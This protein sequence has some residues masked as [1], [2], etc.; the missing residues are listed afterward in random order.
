MLT[1]FAKPLFK[2]PP[3]SKEQSLVLQNIKDGRN[4][5]VDAVA[6]SGKTTTILHICKDNP[7]KKVLVITYNAR[8]KLETRQKKEKLKLFNVEIHSYHGFGCKYYA[9]LCHTDEHILEILK[10]NKKPKITINYDIIILDEQQDMIKIYYQLIKKI[11]NDCNNKEIQLCLFGDIYQNIYKFKNSDDRYLK[12]GDLIF[13]TK[14]EWCKLT[15]SVSYRLTEQCAIFVNRHLLKYDR[16]KTVKTGPKVRYLYCDSFNDPSKEVLNYL[17][18]YKPQEIFVLAPSV[19]TKKDKSPT[20]KLVNTLLLYKIPVYVPTS[21]EEEINEKIIQ[22]KLVLSTFHQ[23]KGLERKVVVV[24]NFDGS[25]FDY[26]ARNEDRYKC[27]NVIYVACTRASECMTVFHHHENNFLN[28]MEYK[29]LEQNCDL[30]IKNKSFNINDKIKTFLKRKI[31]VVDLTRHLS[32]ETIDY[33]MKLINYDTNDLENKIINVKSMIK[34]DDKIFEG[35]SEITGLLLPSIYEFKTKKKSSIIEYVILNFKQ[36]PLKY[37]SKTKEIIQN[38]KKIKLSIAE[39]LYMST[40]FLALNTGYYVKIE[41]IEKFDWI[42]KDEINEIMKIFKSSISKKAKYEEEITLKYDSNT[43]LF[44]RIDIIDNDTLYEIKCTNKISNEHI[45]QLVLYAYM[46]KNKYAHYKLF[47]IYLNK[48]IE[49]KYSDNFKKIIDYLIFTKYNIAKK[50]S[51]DEFL[52]N[53]LTNLTI[54][55]DDSDGNE[56]LSD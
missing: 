34:I 52:N 50:I 23:V 31:A 24:F 36:I 28:F 3:V 32:I 17:K 40:M 30:I 8:L 49:I 46:T 47:Y 9:E 44:G 25:Y 7:N 15:M 35:V 14:R 38:Y 55:E 19:R 41:Q 27:P 29:N 10:K 13:P 11:L 22:N 4:I 51:D 16:I 37:I 1:T 2:L 42:T 43:E 53:C 5:I 48:I 6:G 56:F 21:D 39:L 12:L 45:I 18:T 20:V 26:Y 54:Q 33:V